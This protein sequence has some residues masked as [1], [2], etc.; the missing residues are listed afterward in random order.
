VSQQTPD[1]G[2]ALAGWAAA[3]L[4]FGASAAVLVVELVALRLLAPYL[5]LTLETSTLVIGTALAAIALG[6]WLG[7]RTADVVSPRRAIA[8]LLSFSGAAVAVTP[9]AVRGAGEIGAAGVL[10]LVAGLTIIIPGALLSAVTPMVIKLMLTTLTETGTVV[11]R[12]SGI[13]TAGAIFGTVVTGFVLISRVRV[14]GI[15]VGLGLLLLGAAIVVEIGV[16]RRPPV[17]PVA[18]ILLGTLGGLVAPGGCDAETKYHCAEVQSDPNRPGGRLLVLDALRHSYVDLDDP[19]H[20]EFSYV[21]GLAGVVDGSFESGRALDAYHVGGGGLTFPRYLAETRP[22]TRSLVSEIDAGVVDV[23]TERLGLETG[24]DL[25]VRVE[26]GRTGVRRVPDA[27][28][29]LVIGDAFGGVSVPWHLTTT[30]YVEE[31]R[32]VLR[33]EG[34]Y[35]A[36]IIDF[37]PLGFARAEL[38]TFREVFDHVALAADPFTLSGNGGGNL[39][40]IASDSPI[41]RASVERGFERQRVAWDVIDGPQLTEWIDGAAVLTDDYAPVDQLLT[42]NP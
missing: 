40:A 10:L 20:L 5:G 37:D 18:L 6:A 16:R 24:P 26:D 7:G 25:Q 14:T 2:G 41:D 11:G 1:A 17:H 30:E 21:K 35:A 28:R 12:L 9:F 8:P 32:R 15:M 36:N 31:V 34:V 39:V 19:T 33:L 22:G 4:V 38:A 42:P 23:D 3:S 27:S 29:D 13:G